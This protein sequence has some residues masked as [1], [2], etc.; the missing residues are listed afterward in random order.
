MMKSLGLF[1]IKGIGRIRVSMERQNENSQM[2]ESRQEKK[3]AICPHL[4]KKK[5][6]QVRKSVI[7]ELSYGEMASGEIRGV[8]H[9][10]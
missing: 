2:L 3:K 10:Y 6:G 4:G 8:F 5:E 9:I 1:T 7:T